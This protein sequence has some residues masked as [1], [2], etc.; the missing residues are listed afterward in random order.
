MT[1]EELQQRL[2]DIERDIS[3][4]W[5]VLGTAAKSRQD[6]DAL[7][8]WR[9]SQRLR[10]VLMRQG[11]YRVSDITDRTEVQM[12]ST[13]GIG[14]SGMREIKELMR[15]RGLVFAERGIV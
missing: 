3:D 10:N 11:I 9:I 15:E 13:P 1:N 6:D 12:E 2:E 5:L 7:K 4:I 14:K 8:A